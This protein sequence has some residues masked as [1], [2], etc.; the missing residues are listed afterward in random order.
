MR[1]A[2]CPHLVPLTRDASLSSA[3]VYS[4]LPT[5]DS[6]RYWVDSSQDLVCTRTLSATRNAE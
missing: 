3:T 5:L 1:A 6:H 4:W 2:L